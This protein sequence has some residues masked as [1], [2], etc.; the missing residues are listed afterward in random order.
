MPREK[1]CSTS[2]RRADAL[3]AMAAPEGKVDPAV[4]KPQGFKT[5]NSHVNE[6]EATFL[7]DDLTRYYNMFD[8]VDRKLE[9]LEFIKGRGWNQHPGHPASRGP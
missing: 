1:A 5:W 9:S 7:R 2:P 6:V 8:Q 4:V 3:A